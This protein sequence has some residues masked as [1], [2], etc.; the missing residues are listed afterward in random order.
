MYSRFGSEIGGK[1]SF[2]V[3]SISTEASSP[4]LRWLRGPWPWSRCGRICRSSAGLARYDIAQ[5]SASALSGSMSSFTAITYLPAA[6][7]QAAAPYSARQT[8]VCGMLRSSTRTT[9]LRRLVS[10]SC[11]DTR[12]TPWMPSPWRRCCRYS[13]SSATRLIRLDSLGVTCEMMEVRIASLRRVMHVTSMK[14][15]YSW[16][17]TC[18]WDSPNGAS[19]SRYSVSIQ[20]STTISDSAGTSRSTVFAFTTLIGP[21]TNPPATCSSSM[22]SGTFCAEVKATH[23]GAPST[24]A[25]ASFWRFF[26]AFCQWV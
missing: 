14:A 12:F 8:S 17:L 9:T 24:T 10:G 23:G 25:A 18:P 21:P 5:N 6:R 19:G 7:F 3:A 1:S 16:R 4:L 15:L 2:I 20:P 22:L 11:I 13:G 26:F